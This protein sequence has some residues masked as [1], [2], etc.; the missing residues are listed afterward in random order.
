MKFL[1]TGAT[2][3]I[4]KEVISKLLQDGHEI[5]SLTRQQTVLPALKNTE[6]LVY[7][8]I[9]APSKIA[10]GIDTVIH[11]AAAT[12]GAKSS[13]ESYFKTNVEGTRHLVEICK[14]QNISRF[15]FISSIAAMDKEN[16]DA[17]AVSKKESEKIIVNSHLNWTILR[18]A[19]II[20]ADKSWLSFLEILKKKKFVFVPGDGKQ[21]R[22]PVFTSDVV[23]AIL[24]VLIN[25][26]TCGKKY[27]LAS[28]NPVGY[29]Q[30]LILVR[31][32]FNFSFKIIIVPIRIIKMLSTFKS[33]LPE[34]MKNKINNAH[35][36]LRNTELNIQ[37][38]IFDFNYNPVD[39][40]EGLK[41][42]KGNLSQ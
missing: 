1:I 15:I 26:N 27:T 7:D 31:K 16:K 36:M 39:I 6:I 42:L 37:D 33:L 5:R 41:E 14:E 18:P 34:K 19:E 25:T 28:R 4:G 10:E 35:R 22:H 3:L 20:G 38:A 23:K 13:T 9:D 30:F 2:S 8:L 32:Y 17:Y 40:E 29:F 11:I 21:L 24:Q 12:P